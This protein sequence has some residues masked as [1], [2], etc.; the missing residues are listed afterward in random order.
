MF[1]CAAQ[2]DNCSLNKQ[3]LKGPDFLNSL[4]GV[5]T[6]F[7]MEKVAVVGDIEQMFHQVLVGP[8]D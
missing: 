2:Y 6:K 8:K 7:R 1:D 5:L 4:V 3:L